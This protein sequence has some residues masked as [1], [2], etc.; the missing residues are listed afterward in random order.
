[1]GELCRTVEF[2]KSSGVGGICKTAG[3]PQ[4]EGT[5][6]MCGTTIVFVRGSVG[7]MCRATDDRRGSGV[8]VCLCVFCLTS[9]QQASVTQGRICSD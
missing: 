4:N 9:Q 7:V 8:R 6:E 5:G 3:F 1:M 2:S